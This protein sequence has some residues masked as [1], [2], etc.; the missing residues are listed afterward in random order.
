V[1]PRNLFWIGILGVPI[2]ENN[3]LGIPAYLIR[4]LPGIIL[5][6]AYFVGG[7]LIMRAL[8][9]RKMYQQIGFIRFNLMAVLMLTM[10]LMPIKMVLRW[11][12][13]LHYIVGI[14]E[15][16]LNV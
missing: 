11:T 7:P 5:L 12:L 2:P 14:T 6:L 1:E 9:F 3:L 13:N 10:L 8:F 15:W 4:E 16:F